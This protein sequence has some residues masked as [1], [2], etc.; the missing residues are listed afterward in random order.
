MY[1]AN[2]GEIERQRGKRDQAIVALREAVALAPRSAQAQ[3]N[4]GILHFDMRAFD[5]AAECYQKAIAINPSYPEAYN[6]LGNALRALGRNEE[7]TDNYQRALLLRENYPEAYNNLAAVLRDND[8]IAEAEHAYR[9]AIA[10]RPDY[11]EA[12]NNLAGMLVD[13]DRE[14]DALR[15][16][17]EALAKDGK[18]IP[19]LLQVARTQLHRGNAV[20]AEQAARLALQYDVANAEAYVVL[21]QVLHDTDRYQESL[22]AYEEALSL[23]DEEPDANNFYGVCLK[24]VGRLDDAKAAFSRSLELNPNALGVYSNIADLE[25]FTPE[26]PNF[27]KMQEFLESARG[28]AERALH[29]PALRARQGE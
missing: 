13:Q 24:S 23:D 6:N 19:T 18:H 2:L 17:G 25:K 27:K 20:Q 26:S 5:E 28:S 29:E 4:L 7:A 16:L 3:N 21:G 10:L 15:V 11:L 12:Y 8:Q 9:K 1:H 22:R 14:E